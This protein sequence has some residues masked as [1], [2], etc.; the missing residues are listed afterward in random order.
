MAAL[1]DET[2][3][4][5]EW[6]GQSAWADHLLEMQLYR[7][8]GAAHELFTRIDRL[9]K[10]APNTPVSR[11]LARVYMLVLAA[12]FQG[13]YRPFKLPRAIAD[14]RRRL[15]EYIYRD[16]PMLLYAPDRPIIPEVASRTLEGQA[17]SRFS[18]AQRWAAILALVAVGYTVIAHVAWNR[19][20]AD[21][22]DVT[23]RIVVDSAG[24][25]R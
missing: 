3:T 9:L 14:Y 11:D 2:F 22:E 8:R 7:T 5:L 17:V 16:D 21:L 13:K 18:S 10:D 25:N 23:S 1:A 12:G 15:Y 19:L 20:S 4:H 24:E 6:E